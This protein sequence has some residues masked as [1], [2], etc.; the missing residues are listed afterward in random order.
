MNRRV[1]FYKHNVGEEEL[2][3]LRETVSSVFLTTGPRTR[4]FEEALA[5]YLGVAHCVGV[6]SWTMGAFLALKALDLGPGDEVITTPLTFIA[7][8]NVVLHCGATP[9][10]V[11]VEPS[12]GNLDAAQVER[13]ITPRTRGIIPVHL[14]GQMADMRALREVADRHGLFIL[15]DAAHCI[16]GTRDGVRPGGLGDAAAF[17]FYATKNITSGEGGAVVTNDPALHQR[18]LKLRLHGMSAGAADRYTA[19][20]RHWD[21]ELLGY[22]ANMTDIQAAL[23][24]PQLA[25]ID[26]RLAAKERVCQRYDERLAG[27]PGIM[28]PAVLPGSRH[29][30]HIY[31]VWVDPARRDRVLTGLQ[32]AGIGVAVNFRAIH[33]LS[34]Y[35]RTFGFE[36]G[37]FPEAE[38]IGA[39]TITLPMYPQLTDDEVDYVADTLRGLVA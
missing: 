13:A 30:R 8:A 37:S 17:S 15:E 21:M 39:S 26:E 16:E 32:E 5:S 35:Q 4:T 6:T 18:L 24:L 3:L 11:D 31:T 34:Y 23:L 29:A 33:L 20:Y 38:R 25:R 2:A 9:V 12:T 1:E 27:A 7:T 36:P 10:F 14:Y 22:K 28:T 19:S